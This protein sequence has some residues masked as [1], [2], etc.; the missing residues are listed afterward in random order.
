M[1]KARAA[2]TVSDSG[3]LLTTTRPTAFSVLS[4]EQVSASTQQTSAS[5][6]EIAASA[7]ELASSAAELERVVA[8]FQ[9]S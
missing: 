1:R 9:L 8:T 4:A 3:P 6:Q 2:P 7:Q 5:T